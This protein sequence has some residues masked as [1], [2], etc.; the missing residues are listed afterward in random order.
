MHNSS[1]T[2]TSQEKEH[3]PAR[4][5]K[6]VRCPLLRISVI[7]SDRTDVERSLQ[8]LRHAQFRVKADV[9][10][11][12]EQFTKRLGSKCYNLILAGYPAAKEWETQALKLLQQNSR[13]TPVVFLTDTIQPEAVAE[14]INNG[15]A[16]CI[17][18]ENIGHLP[19]V[20]RRVLSEEKVREQRDRAEE[21][22]RHSEAH[23]R[24]LVGNLTYGMCH[25]TLAWIIR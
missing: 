11:T 19:V 18:M 14:L 13:H 16:D 1:Q 12:S 22:L 4:G 10:L 5:T 21:K 20:I 23:Y 3:F 2:G 25:C 6:T 17:Q 24:A 15:A 7:H 9:V 8:E